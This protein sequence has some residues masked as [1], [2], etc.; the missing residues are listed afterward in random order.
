VRR[1]QIA[2]AALVVVGVLPAAAPATGNSTPSA[3]VGAFYFDGWAGDVSGFHF[4]GLEHPGP[5][6]FFPQ[7]QPLSGW[8]DNTPQALEAQLRWAHEDGISFFVFDW[9]HDPDPSN[10][11]VNMAHDNYLKLHDHDG[12]GY[13]LAYIGNGPFGVPLTE[14]P[15]VADQWVTKDFL[16]PNYVRI[17]G[18]PLL[19]VYEINDVAQLWGGAAGVNE[20]LDILQ[21]AARRHG[22]P[23]VF[24]V[25]THQEPAEYTTDCFLNCGYDGDLLAQHWDALSKY[26]F[27]QDV[28]PVDGAIPYSQLASAQEAIWSRYAAQSAFR[29]IPSIP[30]G[31]DERSSNELVRDSS[32]VPRLFWFVRTP[33]EIGALLHE[34]IDWLNGNPQMRVEPAPA[35]PVV[36]IEAWNELQ[37]GAYVLPTDEDGYGYGQAIAQAVGIP[38]A[39]PPKHILRVIPS[40]RGAVTST[41]RRISCPPACTAAFDEGR[42]VTLTVRAKRGSLFDHWTGCTETDPTCSV[43]LLHDS[44]TRPVILATVQ[45]RRLSLRLTRHVMARGRL[46]AVDGFNGCVWSERVEIQRRAGHR[47]V[48]V[49]STSTDKRGRYS[50]KLRN[51]AGV[52]RSLARRSFVEGHECLPASSRTIRYPL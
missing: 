30:A 38:W 52:Y 51:R 32:G 19:V 14:W 34:A 26:T 21:Q 18:K 25:G 16:N 36:L 20:A 47:W 48:P 45:R 3:R 42:D 31:W 29:F 2:A 39:P 33:A 23:G 17:G 12:V 24:V 27:N 10:G 6:G 40:G 5:L 46:G 43:V 13:A 4:D 50:I 7:R 41:P 8:R 9:F 28:K 35:P 44:T 1:A 49:A 37:E 11:P 15:A 22:L